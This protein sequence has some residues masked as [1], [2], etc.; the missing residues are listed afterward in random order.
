MCAYGDDTTRTYQYPDQLA[1]GED[2]HDHLR[3]GRV[4]AG[5]V[6]LELVHVLDQ[7][8]TH[9]QRAIGFTSVV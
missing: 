5:D 1:V 3:V 8:L 2:R 6:A 9:V 7:L 4:V